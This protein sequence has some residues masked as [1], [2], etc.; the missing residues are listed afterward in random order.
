MPVYHYLCDKCGYEIEEFQS[1]KAKPLDKCPECNSRTYHRV[2]SA[3]LLIQVQGGTTTIGALAD[4]NASK[5]SKDRK[6]YLKRKHKTKPK[7]LHE[8]PENM[9]RNTQKSKPIQW[10][11]QTKSTKAITKMTPKQ[12]IDYIETG[13]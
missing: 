6:K 8:L 1:I 13:D 12:K 5:F 10:P 4:R 2:I 9:S 7:V 3:P 11:G